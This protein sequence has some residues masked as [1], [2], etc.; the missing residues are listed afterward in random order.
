MI[1]YPRT[2]KLVGNKVYGSIDKCYEC[3]NKNNKNIRK[4]KLSG[5][6]M[7]LCPECLLDA[8][9]MEVAINKIINTRKL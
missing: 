9:K 2:K 8:V 5:R 1:E 3:D 4:C 6:D 7:Y